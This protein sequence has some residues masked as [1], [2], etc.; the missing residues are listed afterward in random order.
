MAESH[1]ETEELS[2]GRGTEDVLQHSCAIRCQGYSCQ[3][4]RTQGQMENTDPLGTSLFTGLNQNIARNTK[5][6]Q[7]PHL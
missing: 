5:G 7:C 4:I 3:E 1:T 2:S 6:K